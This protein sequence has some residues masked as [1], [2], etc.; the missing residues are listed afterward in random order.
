MGKLMTPL[1]VDG[2]FNRKKTK[3]RV[4]FVKDVSDG[5]NCYS[6]YRSAGSPENDYP[7]NEQDKYYLYV[8]VNDWLVPTGMTESCLIDRVGF[9][10][11]AGL[12]YGKFENRWVWLDSFQT[13]EERQ[14]AIGEESRIACQYGSGSAA[15]Y[16]YIHSYIEESANRFRNA[17]IDPIASPPDFVGAAYLNL[18]DVC[19]ELS[20]KRKAYYHE[21]AEL[22]RQEQEAEEARKKA[23]LEAEIKAAKA[24]YFGWADSMTPMRFGKVSACMDALV[25]V[26]GKVMTKREFV[27][28]L[29][30]NGYTPKMR[31]NVVSWNRRTGE[32]TK[33]KTEYRMTDGKFS[34]S[35]SKTEFDFAM[36]IEEHREVIG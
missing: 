10:K 11:A 5:Q 15:Q 20:E 6:L 31:E 36:Y 28:Y 35:V 25:R 32:E 22:R 17:Q 18:L 29:F 19:C 34:Y 16:S 12:L 7:R 2:N 14:N 33:P 13:E 27:V 9:Q 26:D 23:E 30:K 21:K 8:L 1:F 4:E 24:K 3:M